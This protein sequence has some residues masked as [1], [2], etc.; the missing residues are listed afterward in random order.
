MIL[1]HAVTATVL[2]FHR[3]DRRAAALLLPYLC[4]AA[5]AAPLNW[6]IRV[7]NG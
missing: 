4:W 1:C 7:E 2:L 6:W 5:F 3:I